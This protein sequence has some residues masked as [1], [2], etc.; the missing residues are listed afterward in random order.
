VCEEEFEG[1]VK[2]LLREYRLSAD[3]YST[4]RLPLLLEQT[5]RSLAEARVDRAEHEHRVVVRRRHRDHLVAGSRAERRAGGSGPRP[6]LAASV[7]P[8]PRRVRRRRAAHY[9]RH[10]SVHRQNHPSEPQSD[11]VEFARE[12]FTGYGTK[13]WLLYESVLYT[14]WSSIECAS[15]GSSEERPFFHAPEGSAKKAASRIQLVQ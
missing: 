11:N 5:D 13:F 14:V 9:L 7:A 8:P 12:G 4:N 15:T 2:L 3:M 1:P 6:P 10:E